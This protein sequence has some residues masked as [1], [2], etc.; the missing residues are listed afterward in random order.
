MSHIAYPCFDDRHWGHYNLLAFV[1]CAA[2]NIC[3]QYLF[4][5]KF[6]ILLGFYLAVE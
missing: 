2:M 5:Y 1:N 6:L 3:V 4:E